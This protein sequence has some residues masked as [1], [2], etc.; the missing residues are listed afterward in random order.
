MKDMRRILA[1]LFSIAFV[2]AFP[3]LF[4]KAIPE[5]NKD[6]VTYMLGQLSGIVGTILAFHFSSTVG[7][8]EKTRQIVALSGQNQPGKTDT[9]EVEADQVT[10]QRR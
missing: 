4:Y 9:M 7:G 5:A 6:L 8:E 3:V 1:L 10:V 2:G